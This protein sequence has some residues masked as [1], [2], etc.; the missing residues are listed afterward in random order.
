MNA[1]PL[2]GAGPADLETFDLAEPALR[3]GCADAGKEVVAD[4]DEPCGWAGSGRR[5]E[6]MTSFSE[7]LASPS[8][9]IQMLRCP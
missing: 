1:E 6:H 9:P 2:L 4:V 7:L 5:G 3:L 8:R